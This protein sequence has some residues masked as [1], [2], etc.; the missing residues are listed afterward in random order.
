[1]EDKIVGS[2]FLLIA[3]IFIST[4]Y[5]VTAILVSNLPYTS[6]EAF[7]QSFFDAGYVLLLFSLIFF[8][9]GILLLVRGFTQH[10]M[11]M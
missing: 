9:V 11:N 1:M 7:Y 2:L 6:K 8:I 5:I 4:Q 3:A 10:K